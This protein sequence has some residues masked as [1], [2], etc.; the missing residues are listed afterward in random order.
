MMLMMIK[1]DTIYPRPLP[2]LSGVVYSGPKLQASALRSVGSVT[3][4]RAG[5]L[6]AGAARAAGGRGGA[7]RAHG[8]RVSRWA[9][10]GRR[11]VDTGTA[12]H[13]ARASLHAQAE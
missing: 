5:G 7:L 6:V 8:A 4:R 12:M 1:D 11:T 2:K 3:R 10:R 13:A 9:A